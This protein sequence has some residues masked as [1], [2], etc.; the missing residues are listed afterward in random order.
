MDENAK[1]PEA[2]RLWLYFQEVINWVK[3]TFPEYRKEMKG[4]AWGPLYNE[5]E[6]KK[7]NSKKLEE[8]IT[9]LMQ[10]DEVRKKSGIY[11]YVLTNDKKHLNLRAF[12]DSQKREVYERQKGICKKCK[13]YF[14]I[15]NM[16]ADHIDPWHKGGKTISENCQMLCQ[17]CNRRKSGK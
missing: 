2:K 17:Q 12:T 4:V 7:L 1:E 6:N 3:A 8:E 14:E 10:D 15:D 11:P 16:E 9:E 13:K 5:F